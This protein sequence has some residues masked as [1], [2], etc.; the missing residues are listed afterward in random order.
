M[1]SPKLK[2]VAVNTESIIESVLTDCL[3]A[4]TSGYDFYFYN[5][6]TNL[7]P[8]S[9]Y[10]KFGSTQIE[11]EE[12]VHALR[13]KTAEQEISPHLPAA[14]TLPRG[15]TIAW[16]DASPDTPSNAAAKSIDSAGWIV[17]KH[18]DGTT[19]VSVAGQI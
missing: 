12:Y 16:W 9:A 17:A 3:P 4:G 2:S 8:Y 18:D 11:Y 5:P 13:L 14:W 10:L 6:G 1:N 15:L 19:Y 7:L